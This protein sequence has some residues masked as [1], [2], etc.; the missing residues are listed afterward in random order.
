M[1]LSVAPAP[2]AVIISAPAL[3]ITVG[4]AKVILASVIPPVEPEASITATVASVAELS[5]SLLSPV[6]LSVVVATPSS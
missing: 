5:V 1:K 6:I 4:D 3:P 2:V